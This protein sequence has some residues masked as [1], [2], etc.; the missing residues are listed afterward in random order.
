MI[1][2][3]DPPIARGWYWWRRFKGDRTIE[4]AVVIEVVL[5]NRKLFMSDTG[6]LS[7]TEF[8]REQF[9]NG[10]NKNEWAGPVPTPEEAP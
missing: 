5:I 9:K 10:V 2:S 7:L 6:D 3:P 1:W 4:F 8:A